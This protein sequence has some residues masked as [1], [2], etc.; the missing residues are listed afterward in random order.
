MEKD[1]EEKTRDEVLG[2]FKSFE[3]V[4]KKKVRDM[5]LSEE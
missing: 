3:K 2:R 4:I 1:E 5:Q